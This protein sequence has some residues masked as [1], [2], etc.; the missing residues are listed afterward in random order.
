M[1]QKDKIRLSV[2]FAKQIEFIA[3]SILHEG[4]DYDMQWHKSYCKQLKELS[5]EVLKKLKQDQYENKRGKVGSI[6]SIPK[7]K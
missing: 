1:T 2:V 3:D 6:K 7:G 4:N 5:E